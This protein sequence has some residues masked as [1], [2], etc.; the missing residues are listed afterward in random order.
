MSDT[1]SLREITREIR[2][3][4]TKKDGS[5]NV[6]FGAKPYLEAMERI[7]ESGNDHSW[8]YN[9]SA[10]TIVLYFL[11]N[12]AQYRGEAAKR[13]KAELRAKYGIK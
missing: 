2:Q 9:D 3:T 11:S 1:R 8:F 6:W 13:I 12:A 4:W 7:A 5:G 10:E